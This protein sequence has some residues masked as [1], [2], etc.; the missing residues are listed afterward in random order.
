M[1]IS[2]AWKKLIT[3]TAMLL[4]WITSIVSTVNAVNYDNLTNIKQNWYSSTASY[5]WEKV[6]Q[7]INKKVSTKYDKLKITLYLYDRLEPYKYKKPHLKNVI[8]ELQ[9][10][11]LYDYIYNELG[12]IPVKIVYVV[13]GDTIKFTNLLDK[14]DYKLRMIW[15]DTPESNPVRYWYKEC[16]GQEA[17]DHLKKLVKYGTLF[18]VEKDKSQWD[19]DRYWR[20]LGYLVEVIQ[21]KCISSWCSYSVVNLNWKQIKD[22]Y[23]W[24]YT[25]NKY[26]PY[27]YQQQFK[28]YQKYAEQKDLWLWSA[29][30]C[31]WER[32]A[33]DKVVDDTNADLKDVFTTGSAS[34]NTT[35]I[36]CSKLKTCEEAKYYLNTCGLKRLDRN[37]DG[38]PCENLCK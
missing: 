8:S 23:G 21:N 3:Y 28:E 5:L 7:L 4:L 10:Y 13:D 30:T 25:Y 35:G 9:D 19:V 24:E 34:C 12:F 32:Q 14:K 22:W 33:V 16:Y 31:S 17:K 20:Q 15:L 6:E 11:L 27:Y 26:H 29:N 1:N 36:Y 37:W 18:F 2:N 38:V